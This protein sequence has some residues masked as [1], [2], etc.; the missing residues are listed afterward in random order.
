MD[1]NTSK[2]SARGTSFPELVFW[3]LILSAALVFTLLPGHEHSGFLPLT[4]PL[5][6]VSLLFLPG[7]F[8]LSLWSGMREKLE[9]RLEYLAFSVLMS[10]VIQTFFCVLVLE[11]G[12]RVR[13]VLIAELVLML[14]T[15]AALGGM[16]KCPALSDAAKRRS[17]DAISWF[18]LA[19]LLGLL[20]LAVM[21]FMSGGF[22][23]R[24]QTNLAR[25]IAENASAYKFSIMYLPGAAHTYLYEP[26]GFLIALIANATHA[27]VIV[28]TDKFWSIDILLA[29][30][31][32]AAFVS[33]A[34]KWRFGALIFLAFF[35]ASIFSYPYKDFVQ[36]GLFIPYPNR[37]GFG[38]GVLVPAGL[39]LILRFEEAKRPLGFLILI[40]AF[41]I[42]LVIFHSRE[43]L[44]LFLVY[45]LF[46]GLLL[47]TQKDRKVIFLKYGSLLLISVIFFAAFSIYHT[48]NVHHILAVTQELKM[49]L[50][51]EFAKM[52]SHPSLA[53]DPNYFKTFPIFVG[54]YELGRFFLYLLQTT[55]PAII[56]PLILTAI[57]LPW[58]L[59]FSK[60]N[61]VFLG[62][63]GF[64]GLLT[65]CYFPVLFTGISMLVGTTDLFQCGTFFFSLTLLLFVC[66][67]IEFGVFI[68]RMFPSRIVF[69]V[70]LILFSNIAAFLLF[71]KSAEKLLGWVMN[72]PFKFYNVH[73]VFLAA[74]VVLSILIYFFKKHFSAN[75]HHSEQLR[76]V[77]GCYAVFLLSVPFIWNQHVSGDTFDQMI[78]KDL[79]SKKAINDIYVDYDRLVKR[80][81]MLSPFPKE[82][83]RFMREGIPPLSRFV[84]DYAVATTIPLYANHYVVHAGTQLSTDKAYYE[85][86]YSRHKAHMLFNDQP[87]SV[88]WK[89]NLEFLEDY[90][91]D[92]VLVDPGHREKLH[93]YFEKVNQKA[94][95]FQIVYQDSEFSVAKVNRSEIEKVLQQS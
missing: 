29:G 35:V 9:F 41:L 34:V 19:G 30:I 66:I 15:C 26:L 16:K 83:V 90:K 80:A 78:A 49:N 84:G 38:P 74:A 58:A 93:S 95:V 14:M 50:R 18:T 63:A 87:I 25:K 13:Y 65:L 73:M 32:G 51:Q 23:D 64:S 86:W 56:F 44:L 60:K 92:Y 54:E 82:L 67:L 28:I 59:I 70:G 75:S 94:A 17:M 2:H 62:I 91:V 79:K 33:T 31:F 5:A 55:R 61:W 48:M 89:D 77:L 4:F 11:M 57:A 88:F 52:I 20:V 85:K 3:I 37:Y 24:E 8:V 53:L 69:C 47:I 46:A 21:A 6:A 1:T 45:S 40:P 27:D 22:I 76:Q 10:I 7:Y 43:G 39:W 71:H 42:T 81:N 68:S 36:T 72:H 12:L